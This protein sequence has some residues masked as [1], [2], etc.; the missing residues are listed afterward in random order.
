[1]TLR[2]DDLRVAG[3]ARA[4]STTAVRD[5]SHSTGTAGLTN[6][7][8]RIVGDRT[9]AVA[10]AIVMLVRTARLV[11]RVLCRFGSRAASIVTPI[12]WAMLATTLL[13]FAVGYGFGILE[14]VVMAVASAIL[15]LIAVTY[16]VGRDSFAVELDIP[17]RHVTVGSPGIGTI[18]VRNP[19]RH[20][21][22]GTRI[23]VP[24]GTSLW[25]LQIPG[26]AGGSEFR[27]DF[28]IPTA[29]RGVFLIGPA[30]T[31]RAD[32]IG[33]MCRQ[34]VWAETVPFFVHP[35]TIAVPSTSTGLIRDLEGQPTSDLSNSDVSFHALREYVPGDERR[36]IHWKSTAKT[37]TYLVR[38][39]EETRRSRLVVALSLAWADFAGD[40]EFE[41]AVSAAGS[42]GL[43]AIR[44]ARDV[45]VVVGR[46]T[47]EFAKKKLLGVRH[48][49]SLNRM[50]LL[51][52]LAGVQRDDASLPL[53]DV[54]R[55]A[56]DRVVGISVAYLVCG[57]L[58]TP[59]TLRAAS[60]QFPV[61]VEV[62]AVVCDPDASPGLRRVAGLNVLTIGHLEDLQ[63]SLAR[64]ATL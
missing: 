49:D 8:T 27:R 62:I 58:T 19:S 30:R 31:V 37:G 29:T 39:F 64:A 21:A 23:D 38:Q 6:A 59:G 35:R 44:D 7:R 34:L 11:R 46:S 45:S 52:D 41:M 61:G 40:D 14:F 33:L 20:R 25:Q 15:L 1:M 26:I 48:L 60:V 3:S 63:R 5:A 10:D 43:R 54:A 32:P 36:N 53:I 17:Q 12:G 22:F 16:L 57:S 2:Q 55:I 47:P 24:R 9:G 18:R 51:D 13:G 42:L 50:R 56:S 4:R 28:A